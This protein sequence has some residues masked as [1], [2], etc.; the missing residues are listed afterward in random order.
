MIHRTILVFQTI[1]IS[2]WR[3]HSDP[4]AIGLMLLGLT[5]SLRTHPVKYVKV[6]CMHISFILDLTLIS[7][8]YYRQSNCVFKSSICVGISV[9]D[10]DSF[11]IFQSR[12]FR[13]WLAFSNS[14][15]F[16]V[17]FCFLHP[18]LLSKVCPKW[19]QDILSKTLW[20]HLL[21]CNYCVISAVWLCHCWMVLI[22]V[23]QTWYLILKICISL[24]FLL[25]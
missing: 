12:K 21:M 16:F 1:D 15:V 2:F 25:N 18:L 20:K 3:L 22:Y 13:T 6:N 8:K 23:I 10:I 19:E 24:H 17:C 4:F 11:W 5:L 9:E 14:M 7:L